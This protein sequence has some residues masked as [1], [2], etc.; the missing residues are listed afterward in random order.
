MTAND[1]SQYRAPGTGRPAGP[2]S[3]PV[4]PAV[5]PAGTGTS[6]PPPPA[7]PAGTAGRSALVRG[8]TRAGLVLVVGGLGILVWRAV[9]QTL[10]STGAANRLGLRPPPGRSLVTNQPA[11]RLVG[12]VLGDSLGVLA[13]ALL[14]GVLAGFAAAGL[15]C[16]LERA[17]PNLGR[18]GGGLGWF[19]GL[20]W[21]PPVPVVL[22]VAA[23]AV[24]LG[25][26]GGGRD[27]VLILAL[28]GM[29]AAL[30]A[31]APGERWQRGAWLAGGLAGIASAGR[32]LAASAGALVVGEV[33]VAR[34]GVGGLLARGLITVDREVVVAATTVLLAV[35]L[36]GLV[37]GALAGAFA[38][39]VDPVPVQ[40]GP[41][42]SRPATWQTVAAL[43]TVVI[44]ALV[45]AGSLVAGSPTTIDVTDRLAGPSAAH[46]L[47][48]D[49]LGRDNLARLLVGYRQTV[50]AALAGLALATIPGVLWGVLAGLAARF[51]PRAGGPVAEVILGPGQLIVAAPLLLAGFVLVGAARWPAAAAMAVVLAPRLALAVAELARPLPPS[52]LSV[53]RTAAGMLLY[54]LGVAVVVLVGLQVLGIGTSPPIPTLGA[55]LAENLNRPGLGQAA[56]MAV[57]TLATIAPFL[58]AGWTLLRHPRQAE[59]G[60]SLGT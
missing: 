39:F 28:A 59:A 10:M 2:V 43:A 8:L 58:L 9:I 11:L 17:N 41:D 1:P 5:P 12:E 32:A 52:I 34:P 51:L 7:A 27:L 38:D 49:L 40:A 26:A 14:L 45:V 46:P 55:V 22:I 24:V 33:L 57:A 6:P 3:G 37:V 50:L 20:L 29:V 13:L 60:A 31:L 47:G 23:L 15:R 19:I 42:R 16:A 25:A 48:T 30:V 54:T 21:T 18:A 36:V 53:I 44:P 35:A 56:F 4:P